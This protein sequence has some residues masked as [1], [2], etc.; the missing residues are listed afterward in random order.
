MINLFMMALPTKSKSLLTG[1]IES[2]QKLVRDIQSHDPRFE[3]NKDE[4]DTSFY[5]R[6]LEIHHDFMRELEEEKPDARL[7]AWLD[8]HRP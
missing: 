5:L 1:S 7:Q 8:A 3:Q 2:H 4:T 6:A